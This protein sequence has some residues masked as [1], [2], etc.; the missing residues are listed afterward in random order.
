MKVDYKGDGQ[1]QFAWWS[2]CEEAR[3]RRHRY[4]P[5]SK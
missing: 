1:R 3:N 5:L 2:N 4:P